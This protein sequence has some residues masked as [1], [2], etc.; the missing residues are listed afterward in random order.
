MNTMILSGQ[1]AVLMSP[2]SDCAAVQFPN[3]T[4]FRA[5]QKKQSTYGISEISACEPRVMPP[6]LL[7]SDSDCTRSALCI[8]DCA[9]LVTEKV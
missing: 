6:C 1:S 5:A 9:S 8:V 7:Y 3:K 4:S 2:I